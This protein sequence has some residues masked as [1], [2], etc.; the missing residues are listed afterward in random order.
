VRASAVGV[1]GQSS[2]GLAGKFEGHV[3]TTGRITKAYTTGTSSQAVPIA[4]GTVRATDGL[5]LSGT[6]NVSSSYDPTNH[7]YLVTIAN[8]TYATSAYITSV[9]PTT[10]AQPRFAT[11]TAVSGQL[12]V[13][14]FDA[15]GGLQQ[16]QFSF[17]TYRP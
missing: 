3:H 10:A 4:Y 16:A 12:A 8:E 7:R 17:V 5:L 9:T 14:I 11:T 13:R 1:L 15:N 6:P 2:T